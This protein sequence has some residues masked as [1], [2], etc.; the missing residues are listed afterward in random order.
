MDPETRA[1][2]EAR[3]ADA[4]AALGLDDPRQPYRRRLRELRETRPEAFDTAIGH[5]EQHVLPS[6]AAGDPIEAWLEYGRFL[7]ALSSAAELTVIDAS[8]RARPHA[9]PLA[10]Q[11][12]A[13]FMPAD[14]AVP[15]LVAAVPA[16][17]SAAQKATL[18]LLVDRKLGVDR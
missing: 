8:G 12:L 1:R 10:A 16:R 4:A 6:L 17:P 11:S 3:L 9:P 14:T 13:L 18:D 15:P 7:A 5:Y 2:A